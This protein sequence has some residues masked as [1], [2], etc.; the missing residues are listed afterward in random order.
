MSLEKEI[1][2]G[3]EIEKEMEVG[4]LAYGFCLVC[5][6]DVGVYSRQSLLSP[7]VLLPMFA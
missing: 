5:V 3:M 1:G 6:F 2:K 4:S 7:L